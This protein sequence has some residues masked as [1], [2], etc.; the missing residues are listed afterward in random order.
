MGRQA[1]D[2]RPRVK[3]VIKVELNEKNKKP[4]IIALCIF[5]TIAIISFTV[6]LFSLLE[7]EDGW[8]EIKA[9]DTMLGLTDEIVLNYCLG[10]G[11]ASASSEQKA[12]QGR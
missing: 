12:G 4:R 2:K 5:I 1:R 8:T 10:A 9:Q 3:P 7:E 11:D 6:F